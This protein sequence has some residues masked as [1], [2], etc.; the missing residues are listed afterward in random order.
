MNCSACIK[1]VMNSELLRCVRCNLIYHHNCVNITTAY[2][3]GQ[4]AALK[5]TW[6]CPSCTNITSRVKRDCTPVRSNVIQSLDMSCDEFATEE[7]SLSL[8]N[9]PIASPLVTV[10]DGKVR[11][12]DS[13]S[14]SISLLQFEYLLE[15]KLDAKL[16]KSINAAIKTI[17]EEFH[18]AISTMKEEFSTTTDFLQS[19]IKD[20]E[21]TV[22]S[23]QKK[24][25]E[26]EMC[27]SNLQ[28]QLSN[29]IRSTDSVKL[30]ATIAQLNNDLNEREQQTLLNDVE[31]ACVP[32]FDGESVHHIAVCIGA[33][34]GV[35][36]EDRDIVSVARVGARQRSG[37]ESS[38]GVAPAARP[39]PLVVRLA[40]RQ[41][42][43]ELL[44][45]A[46]VRRG[47][48]TEDLGLP[49]HDPR[50][51]YLN[52]RLTK[53]NRVL[54]ARARAAASNASWKFAWSKEGKIFVRRDQTSKVIRLRSLQELDAVFSYSASVSGQK[55]N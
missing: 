55:L 45:Q 27:N 17:K 48:N 20:L 53:V 33:K 41:L 47:A 15:T 22:S 10:P 19:S 21:S 40:R 12:K 8:L 35:Q 7:N 49:R 43:D 36:L 46:R 16:S 30:E 52:E 11:T 1:K 29:V 26:V 23:L 6:I 25:A 4:I 39:R 42:R 18:S 38:N 54:L 50:T 3:M 2:Y 14:P 32:E 51:F 31:V 9:E 44:R 13:T 24:V 5:K 37:R 28:L 34:L